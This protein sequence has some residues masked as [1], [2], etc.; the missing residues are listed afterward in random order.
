[1]TEGD[2]SQGLQPQSASPSYR[3]V[4]A[5]IIPLSVGVLYG[6]GLLI[7]NIDLG[8]YGLLSVDLAR[9]Q[10]I[11]AGLLWAV[12][13]GPTAFLVVVAG[14]PLKKDTPL[15]VRPVI[16]LVM[17][18]S[19]VWMPYLI[20]FLIVD[21]RSFL[22]WRQILPVTGVLYVGA[23]TL[24]QAFSFLRGTL[25]FSRKHGVLTAL[26]KDIFRLLL[27][28]GFVLVGLAAYALLLYPEIPRALGGGK[29]AVVEV[30]ISDSHSSSIAWD[31]LGMPSSPDK[32]T[33]G[34]V[35]LVFETEGT[36]TVTAAQKPYP[37]RWL[38][39]LDPKTTVSI[40]RRIVTAVVYHPRSSGNP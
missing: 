1:M 37:Q 9:P 14:T 21:T 24:T 15:W 30:V 35:L 27:C 29:K 12:L 11:M 20:A 33:V 2:H 4:P 40:D 7:T 19:S 18:A 8:P 32:T 34:P 13:I 3:K 5:S 22:D 25:G 39:R 31:R 28:I 16:K 6:V 38:R 26:A 23:I 17:W 36:V 10:Y